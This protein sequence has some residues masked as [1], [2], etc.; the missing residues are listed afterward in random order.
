LP[1]RNLAEASEVL[2][3]K[4]EEDATAVRLFAANEEIGDHLK[5]VLASRGEKFEYT[6]DLHR[7]VM[8][9]THGSGELPAD[10]D[11]IIALTQYAVPLRYADI[12]DAE[13]LNRDGAL[14]LVEQVRR[15]AETE[16]K[17]NQ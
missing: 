4:A 3:R 7:L 17:S 15:W 9:V 16:F 11:A 5:S 6:H 14:K 8:L 10:V 1:E 13:P 2:A 12:L